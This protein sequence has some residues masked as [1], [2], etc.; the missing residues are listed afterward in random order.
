[1]QND[2]EQLFQVHT[3]NST[4]TFTGDLPNL[5]DN[6]F[7]GVGTISNPV[8]LVVP[9]QYAAN[10]SS[11]MDATGKFYGGY[12]KMENISVDTSMP[13]PNVGTKRLT[14]ITRKQGNNELER[15]DMTY[16]DKGRIVFFVYTKGTRT[17]TVS[18]TYANDIIYVEY[19]TSGGTNKYE[20]H[21]ANGK[22]S[23]API[24][25]ESENMTGNRTF[26]Y[27]SSDQMTKMSIAFD[28]S[29]SRQQ[30]RVGWDNGSP[31]SF[32]YWR[33]NTTDGSEKELYNSTFTLGNMQTEP[34]VHAI[35]GMGKGNNVNIDDDIMELMAFYPFVGKLPE[36][37]I[38]KTIYT[39]SSG[40]QTE[41]NYVYES[42][43]EGDI[44]KVTIESK[45]TSTIY[46]L[47]WDGSS[48]S[49]IDSLNKDEQASDVIYSI[50]GQ[51]LAAP[52]KGLNIIGGKKIVIK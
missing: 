23:Y 5:K 28:G 15:S 24:T 12:F 51:R 49:G 30:I 21:F 11:K 20:F 46:T 6:T 26:E 13:E 35:F 36:R 17:E 43:S 50:S 2:G 40:S 47:D 16:D 19:N 38:E 10:Y 27:D 18:Y 7:S 48:Y 9:S 14:A 33:I 25:L 44:V 29:T 34:V 41:Y 22:V 45:G 52:Q 8:E 4:I 32:S 39:D 31:V 1:M 3:I 37:L 42:N